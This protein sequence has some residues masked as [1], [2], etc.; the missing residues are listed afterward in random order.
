MTGEKES[1]FPALTGKGGA[2]IASEVLLAFAIK[3]FREGLLADVSQTVFRKDKMVA[4][5][6]IAIGLHRCSPSTIK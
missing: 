3:Q 5:V 2:F 1:A 4:T 6:D